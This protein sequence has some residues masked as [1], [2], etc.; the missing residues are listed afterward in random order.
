VI[1]AGRFFAIIALMV[2]FTAC[3][4]SCE[5]EA[6]S[7]SQSESTILPESSAK[8]TPDVTQEKV[9]DIESVMA[10]AEQIGIH[11]LSI[12]HKGDIMT[13]ACQADSYSTFTEYITALGESGRFSTPIPSPPEGYPYIKAGTINLK[14][15][16]QYI[17]MPAVYYE[18]NQALTP[19]T[20]SDAIAIIVSIAKK[21]GIDISVDSDKFRVP[22]PVLSQE[23]V[24]GDTYNLISF[25]NIQVQGDYDN[26]M[27]FV[28]DLDSGK[29][30]QT[31]VLTELI[32]T[33]TE[34]N[35]EI[36]AK[37]AMSV[38]IYSKH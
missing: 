13:I 36:E 8:P 5:Q 27:A 10:K 16:Y 9:K 3:S 31:M 14:P 7:P 30:L 23:K 29:T 4:V 33:P 38:D 19:M 35:G 6:S 1:L 2:I 11:V 17:D 26:V 25:R 22:A 15:K 24:G 12:S 28:T 32:F 34:P 20:D 21:S 18:V 37:A